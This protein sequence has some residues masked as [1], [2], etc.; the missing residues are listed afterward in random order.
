MPR[1]PSAVTGSAFARR[2]LRHRSA[3]RSER[4][5]AVGVGAPVPAGVP[6]FRPAL[7]RVL[8]R[9]AATAG[10]H[11]EQ[12]R[13]ALECL[14]ASPRCGVG[15]ERAVAIAQEGCDGSHVL[16]HRRLHPPNGV[17]GLG[18]AHELE[19]RRDF[20][21]A[22]RGED[23]ERYAARVQVRRIAQLPG[24][25]RAAFAL[26]LVRCA[27]PPHVLVDQEF[28]ATL[29]QVEKRN[30]SARTDDRRGRIELHHRQS[31]AGRRDRVTRARVR[32]L[33]NEQFFPG[34]LPGGKVDDR[35]LGGLGAHRFT[36]NATTPTVHRHRTHPCRHARPRTRRPCPTRGRPTRGRRGGTPP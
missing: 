32:L 21:P 26:T 7:R 29:E 5:S 10:R 34:G 6:P 22:A 18:V 28:V 8:P 15:E 31:S 35:R 9:L 17:P 16:A 11:V 3:R 27:V 13:H 20:F 19:I 33:A 36:I 24:R 2:P 25:E 12:G 4:R 23:R 30:R 1:R 14:V